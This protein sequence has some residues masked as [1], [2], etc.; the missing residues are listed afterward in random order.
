MDQVQISQKTKDELLEQAIVY[1][2]SQNYWEA[3]KACKY[4]SQIDPNC[5]RAYHGLGLIYTKL[6]Y[7]RKAFDAYNCASQLDPEN[8]KIVFDM[9]ELYFIVKDYERARIHYKKASKLDSNY[10]RFY[11][12]RLRNLI[13]LVWLA[14]QSN[15]LGEDDKAVIKAFRNVLLFDPNNVQAL[16][17]FREREENE[18]KPKRVVPYER[19]SLDEWGHYFEVSSGPHTF[20]CRCVDCWEP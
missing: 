14:N 9:G 7:Y 11:H 10:E 6:K 2:K 16:S 15:I 13:D 1:M 19:P 17:F 12:D 20:N 8:V 18:T 5:P 3:L 4:A